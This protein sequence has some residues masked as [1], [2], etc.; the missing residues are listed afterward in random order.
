MTRFSRPDDC[1]NCPYKSKAFSYLS[2]DE[3]SSLQE[4]CL[5]IKF[6]KGEVIAKQGTPASH[7][8]YISQGL[9]KLYVEGNSRNIII[10]LIP[11]GSF[12]GLHSIFSDIGIYNFSVAAITETSICML[13]KDVFLAQAEK[14]H[15]FL[16]EVT[17]GISACADMSLDKILSLS[18][19]TARGRLIDVLLYFAEDIYKSNSFVLPITRRELAELCSISTENAVRILSELRKE[20]LIGIEGKKLIIKQ[21]ALLKKLLL[22][23]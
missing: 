21:P 15:K 10:R 1:R 7:S 23:S 9:V 5:I 16:L 12:I 13:P 11:E 6:K 22:I 18:E 19:K 20:G 8:M 3:I 2:D 14:N 17:K 4:K